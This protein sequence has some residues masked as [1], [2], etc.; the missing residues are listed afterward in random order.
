LISLHEYGVIEGVS[1]HCWHFGISPDGRYLALVFA[2]NQNEVRLCGLDGKVF[3]VLRGHR[4]RIHAV[5][6]A[7]DGRTIASASADRTVRISTPTG[8]L[9]ALF[10][11]FNDGVE[12]VS[13]APG[14]SVLAG[15]QADG[16][17][18]LFDLAGN[19]IASLD[20]PKGRIYC[21]DWSSDRTLLAAGCGDKNLYIFNIKTRKKGT[22]PHSAAVYGVSF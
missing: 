18:V 7:A 22:F 15:G 13:Y 5:A 11:R 10:D 9:L 3:K 2:D 14:G 21:L 20:G 16:K 12:S 8:E 17:I 19:H 6:F 1:E 4:R